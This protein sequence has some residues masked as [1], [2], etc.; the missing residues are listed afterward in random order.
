[1]RHQLVNFMFSLSQC[2]NKAAHQGYYTNSS[3]CEWDKVPAGEAR[4]F[5]VELFKAILH[6]RVN[7]LGF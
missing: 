2:F 7:A 5:L 4:P 6:K 1:M 3:L